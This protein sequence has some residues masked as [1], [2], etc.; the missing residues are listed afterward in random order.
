M[1]WNPKPPSDYPI[2]D[3]VRSA[4]EKGSDVRIEIGPWRRGLNLS[5][6]FHWIRKEVHDSWG[7]LEGY[8]VIDRAG[9]CHRFHEYVGS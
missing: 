7:V 1:F 9:S 6:G 5:F 8:C 3:D 2:P 4:V